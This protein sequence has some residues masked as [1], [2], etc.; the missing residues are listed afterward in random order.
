MNIQVYNEITDFTHVFNTYKSFINHM[1]DL[2]DILNV[3][4]E[5]DD[6]DN[7]ELKDFNDVIE[8]ACCSN[9]EIYFN[10]LEIT[11]DNVLNNFTNPNEVIKSKKVICIISKDNK[12]LITNNKSYS[13]YTSDKNLESI[14]KNW[15]VITK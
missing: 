14:L 7:Y 15:F 13:I 3:E 1:N 11:L 10:D 2:K 4:H 5:F 6:I 9:I 12:D 8:I